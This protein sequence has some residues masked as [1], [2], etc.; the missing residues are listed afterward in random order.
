[1]VLESNASTRW[2]RPLGVITFLIAVGLPI[3]AIATAGVRGAEIDPGLIDWAL[4]GV[5]AVMAL[6]TFALLLPWAAMARGRA[7]IV[8]V[9]LST[10]ALLA[11]FV[12][13]W[14]MVPVIFG[15][16][17]AW[18]GYSAMGAPGRPRAAGL[19]S[20]VL[21]ALAAVASVVAYIATS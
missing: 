2:L 10:V 7:T 14:T 3:A 18:L 5:V 4:V 21:G 19:V 11:S 16:A 13:F 17:G 15:T 9:T 1:M 12:F 20:M 6:T 8:G